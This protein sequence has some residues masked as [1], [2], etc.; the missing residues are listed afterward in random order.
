MRKFFVSWTGDIVK[1]PKCRGVDEFEHLQRAIN[2][3]A[4]MRKQGYICQLFYGTL[5]EP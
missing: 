5:I 3:M 4:H 2:H 1:D